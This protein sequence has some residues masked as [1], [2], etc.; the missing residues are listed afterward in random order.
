MDKNKSTKNGVEAVNLCIKFAYNADFEEFARM[1]HG[2]AFS[3]QYVKAKFANMRSNFARY[4]G[5]LDAANRCRFMDAAIARAE[6]QAREE[7]EDYELYK[8]TVDREGDGAVP[9]FERSAE[10]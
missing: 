10:A 9:D 7:G 3:D 4:W 2:R 1:L 8:V 6:E 5:S